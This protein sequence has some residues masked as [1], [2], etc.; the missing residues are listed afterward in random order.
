MKNKPVSKFIT[1]LILLSFLCAFLTFGYAQTIDFIVP[2][3]VQPV[4]TLPASTPLAEKPVFSV[5]LEQLHQ[6]IWKSFE[7]I[8][9]YIP[10]IYVAYAIVSAILALYLLSKKRRSFGLKIIC[11]LITLAFPLLGIL[12]AGFVPYRTRRPQE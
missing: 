8:I 9:P 5:D 7:K 12:F 1:A 10:Y 6:G 2:T 4:Q 11:F 3:E